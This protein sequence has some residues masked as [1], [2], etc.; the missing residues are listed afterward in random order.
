MASNTPSSVFR[1]ACSTHRVIARGSQTTR[2]ASRYFFTEGRVRVR[3]QWQAQALPQ[4][5]PDALSPLEDDAGA[6]DVAVAAAAAVVPAAAGAAGSA[7]GASGLASV[8]AAPLP[9][10]RKSVTYQ[11]EPFSW[12]PAAVS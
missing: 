7:L 5:P 8:L 11:P 2:P 6:V 1:I 4:P 3:V 10:P 12:K 9:L